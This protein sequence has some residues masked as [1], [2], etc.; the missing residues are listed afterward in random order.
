MTEAEP[1]IRIPAEWTQFL[2]SLAR[3][4]TAAWIILA[5][6]VFFFGIAIK[7]LWT[8]SIW[9]PFTPLRLRW[10]ALVVTH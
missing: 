9:V 7:G 5:F 4:E 6:G 10:L 2:S 1:L 8:G 3:E